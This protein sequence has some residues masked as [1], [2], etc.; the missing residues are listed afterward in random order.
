MNK[1][2]TEIIPCPYC[3]SLE[4]KTWAIDNGFTAVQCNNCNLVYVNPRPLSS[5]IDEAVRTGTHSQEANSK[6]VITRRIDSKVQIY[7]KIFNDIFSDVWQKQKTISWLDVGAGFGEI[8]E[9]ISFVAPKGSNIQG[10]EPMKPKAE[11]ARSRG[12]VIHDG[13]IESV[14]EK[15]DV[16]SLVNVFSH[17]PDFRGFLKDAKGVLNKNGE[18]FI[19]TG[20]A[21][22]FSRNKV[23]GEISLPDHL[24][25]AGE[26][27]MR[28][29]LEEAGF[30]VISIKKARIDTWFE[31][32]KD[33]VKFIIRRPIVLSLPYTSP[34]RSLRIRARLSS[35]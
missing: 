20:N 15:F 8:V 6:N 11:H 14:T 23:P 22:E 29:F 27:H 18:I 16:I 12:L 7:R 13:Y 30:E 26:S 17:I 4:Y 24:V 33:I 1:P 5:M 32:V 28:G 19:E 35:K 25:F 9:A 21:A 10:L 2:N 3:S 34:Y 31:F